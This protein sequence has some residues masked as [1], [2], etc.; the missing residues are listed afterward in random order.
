MRLSTIALVALLR[1]GLALAQDAEYLVPKG[2][3]VRYLKTDEHDVAHFL[4]RFQVTGRYYY[5]YIPDNPDAPEP[6]LYLVPDPKPRALLPYRKD[7]G[8]VSEIIFENPEEVIRKVL[9]QEV[10][11]LVRA[12]KRRSVSGEV[13]LIVS[14][15]QATVEC[16]HAY[17]RV[18]FISV[19][20]PGEY[21]LS[22][23]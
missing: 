4:G 23:P 17:Y 11:Q 12:N 6:D 19:F 21:L 10:V 5:G 3:P 20:R 13:T 2:S 18:R 9:P 7:R 14:N 22:S 15:Y 16:D 1:S 8:P